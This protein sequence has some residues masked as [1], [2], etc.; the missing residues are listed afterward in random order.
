MRREQAAIEWGIRHGTRFYYC[1]NHIS[2]I[3][4]ILINTPGL[5]EDWFYHYHYIFGSPTGWVKKGCAPIADTD[6]RKFEEKSKE[7]IIELIFIDF[8]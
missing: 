7:Q 1:E 2:N 5:S 3:P 8:I 6:F 4:A